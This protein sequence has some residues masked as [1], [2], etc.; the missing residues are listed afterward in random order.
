MS[1]SG[2]RLHNRLRILPCLAWGHEE[3]LVV[4]LRSIWE[5]YRS[6]ECRMIRIRL[7][8][9]RAAW[10]RAC[11][12]HSCRRVWVGDTGHRRQ[13]IPVPRR[14][15]HPSS[16]FSTQSDSSSTLLHPAPALIRI[17]VING[18]GC[19]LEALRTRG[20]HPTA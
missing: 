15:F 2:K 18:Y 13:T 4:E 19:V 5:G 1:R 3:K 8:S 17:R 20:V 6:E 16:V 14:C 9:L 7:L 12:C 10:L 11:S